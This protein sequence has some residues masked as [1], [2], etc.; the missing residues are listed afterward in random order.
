MTAASRRARSLPVSAAA[1]LW[2]VI[3][4]SGS[5]ALNTGPMATPAETGMPWNRVSV[6]PVGRESRAGSRLCCGGGGS[7]L[8]IEAGFH[9]LGEGVE[10]LLGVPA[11][12]PE[13]DFGAWTS[14]QH[15]QSH[16]RAGGDDL[17][18]AGDL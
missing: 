13:F 8:F 10:R 3:L 9:Q 14:A 2:R 16:D 7:V 11:F 1:T 6:R 5:T 4:G 15:H 18:V 12:G 17:A